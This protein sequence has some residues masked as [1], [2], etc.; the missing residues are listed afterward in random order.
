VTLAAAAQAYLDDTWHRERSGSSQRGHRCL[1][2]SLQAF[3]DKRDLT[4]LW[5]VRALAEQA[6]VPGA[7]VETPMQSP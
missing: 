3:A 2:R 5:T 6:Q 7:F 4:G 1:L